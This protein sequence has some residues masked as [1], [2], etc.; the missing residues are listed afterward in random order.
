MGDMGSTLLGLLAA[1]F[2][3]LGWEHGLFPLWVPA[4]LFS[5]FWIDATYTVFKRVH[6]HER[7]WLPHRSHI[8]QRLVLTGLGHTKVVMA[9]YVLMLLCALSI[10]LPLWLG[11]GYNLLVPVTWA[12]IYAIGLPLLEL[13]LSRPGITTSDNY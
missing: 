5:P 9:E 10:L 13:W 12:V 4:V 1:V 7:I 8:Y 6:R 11:L 3:L 2:S